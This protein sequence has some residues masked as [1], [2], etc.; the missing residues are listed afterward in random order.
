MK[1]L[2]YLLMFISLPLFSFESTNLQLLYSNDFKGDAFIYDTKDGKKTTLTFEHY[3]T[4]SYGDFFMFVDAMDGEKFDGTSFN[5]YTELAPRFSFSKLLDKDLSSGILKDIY[6]ATQ[7]NIGDNF[8]AYLSGIGVDILV[9]GLKVFSL[10]AYH[11]ADNLHD[12]TYQI[13]S[14]YES[15]PIYGAYFRGFI[16]LTGIDITTHNQFLF[17][18]SSSLNIKEKISVGVEWIYYDFNDKGSSSQTSVVQAMIKY[19]F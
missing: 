4:W 11:K 7:L 9:P 19:D 12:D 14:V 13:T 16:D 8:R 18:L 6:I 1:K 2:L 15:E 3:R 10:N 17:D 5:V